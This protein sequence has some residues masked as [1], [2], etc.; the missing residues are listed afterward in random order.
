MAICILV[1]DQEE[2]AYDLWEK[3]KL[4]KAQIT[5]FEVIEPTFDL[6][7]NSKQEKTPVFWTGV[8]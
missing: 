4:N 2:K 8:F 7:G 5:N 6:K 3:L 1:L